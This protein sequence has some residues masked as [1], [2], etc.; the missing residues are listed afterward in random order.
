MKKRAQSTV[1]STMLLIFIVIIIASI[2]VVFSSSFL[3]R[4]SQKQEFTNSVRNLDLAIEGVYYYPATAGALPPGGPGPGGDLEI[5]PSGDYIEIILSRLDNEDIANSKGVRFIFHLTS[6][7]T[8]SYDSLYPIPESGINQP[9]YVKLSDIG[10]ENA[11]EIEKVE[12]QAIF[13]DGVS[14]ILDYSETKY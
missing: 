9:Y 12:I 7:K 5:A 6:G 1:I 14:K 13:N 11:S 8:I 3:N 2:I 4:E 10:I